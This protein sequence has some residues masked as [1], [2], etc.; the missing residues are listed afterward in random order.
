VA[1]KR[2][3]DT[4]PNEEELAHELVTKKVRYN[5]MEDMDDE[6]A[7]TEDVSLGPVTSRLLA[8]Q[9]PKGQSND[10][11]RGR[12]LGISSE[13]SSEVFLPSMEVD[14]S[15]ET[16]HTRNATNTSGSSSS[17]PVRDSAQHITTQNIGTGGAAPRGPLI[18]SWVCCQCKQTNKADNCPIRCP[19]EGHYKCASC[20]VY[21]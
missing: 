9:D 10:N 19:L 8:S 4:F 6:A 2:S 15:N 5:G 12:L 21:R 7:M 13:V 16:F 11:E 18:G 14:D 1:D 20:H 17:R 3:R